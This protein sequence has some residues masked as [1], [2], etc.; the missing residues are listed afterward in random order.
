MAANSE[1]GEAE[2]N[3]GAFVTAAGAG[4]PQTVLG[5]AASTGK[6]VLGGAASTG[7]TVLGRAASTGKIVLAAW[8]QAGLEWGVLLLLTGPSMASTVFPQA[9]F[10]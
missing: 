5:R 2:A 8:P 7:K 6:T 9:G 1:G 10:G 4:C 3:S